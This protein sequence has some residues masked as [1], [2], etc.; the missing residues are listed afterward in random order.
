MRNVLIVTALSLSTPTLLSAQFTTPLHEVRKA[1]LGISQVVRLLEQSTLLALTA[2]VLLLGIVWGF[3]VFREYARLNAS[4]QNRNNHFTAL[5]LLVVGLGACCSSCST[6]QRAKSMENRPVRAAENR[7]CPMNQHHYE[8]ANASF[9]KTSTYKGYSNWHG[10][11]F[12]RFCGQW[13][14]RN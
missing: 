9:N 12:C 11:A 5:F 6:M 10:H 1:E 14:N 2:E 13:I 3:Y 8:H 4:K 7:T